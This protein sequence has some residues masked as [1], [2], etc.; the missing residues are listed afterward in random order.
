MNSVFADTG[1]WIA[2]FNPKDRWHD[3]SVSLYQSLEQ[4]QVRVFTS[5][6]VL[7]ELLNFFSKIN[8]DLA[9]DRHF[10]QAGFEAL[11]R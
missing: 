3:L 4:Q 7:T 2:L 6:M 8:A 10:I 11:L 1:F 5:E 9:H